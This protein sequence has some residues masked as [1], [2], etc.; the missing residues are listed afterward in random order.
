MATVAAKEHPIL[1]TGE[2]VRAILD[3]RKTQT[4]RVMP[5]QFWCED[6]EAW[7][8][9]AKDGGDLFSM[10]EVAAD[11]PCRYGNPGDRLW[12]RETW[13]AWSRTSIEY[14]EWEP[15]TPD[16]RG[17]PWAEWVEQ[18]GR[19][20]A[21][22]YRATSES[23][24]P[25]TP[26]IHIPR[27]ASRITLEVTDVRVQRVQEIEIEDIFCEGL[28]EEWDAGVSQYWEWFAELWNRINEKRGYGWDVNPWVWAISF[29]PV[30]ER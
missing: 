20:D 3:G 17:V 4:R 10:A 6:S 11:L 23:T 24:G 19:P 25:W 18:N 30:D 9:R 7:Y 8:V 27:W 5:W 13:Q 22:E 26:S 12:V 2:M 16:V 21:I 28:P 1:F 29:R 14:D 15:I